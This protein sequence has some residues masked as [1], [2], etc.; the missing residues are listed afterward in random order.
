MARSIGLAPTALSKFETT[1]YVPASEPG[2]PDWMAELR[3]TFETAG[4]EF[5]TEAG[6]RAGVRLREPEHN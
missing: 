3:A 6:G 5:I 2:F 1:G 4:V